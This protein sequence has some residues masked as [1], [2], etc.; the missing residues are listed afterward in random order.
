MK[1]FI[2]GLIIGLFI[3]A[4]VAYCYFRFG[5][6]PVATSSAP[7][8]FEKTM[9]RMALKARITKEAPKN[10]PIPP[11]AENLTTGA[12]VY[13]DNCAFCHGWP[14]QPASKAA[15]GM[16]PLPPQL[17][18]PD[19]MVTDDPVGVTYWKVKNGI[20]MT[21][22]PGFGEMLSDNEMWQVSEMLAHADKLPPATTAALQKP[23]VPSVEQQQPQPPQTKGRLT[24]KK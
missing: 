9:A 8:P 22:M 6:A 16:F 12:K 7:M 1:S 19:E 4:A 18:T 3:P 21:G 17:L 13:T 10:S 2:I 24:K 23:P 20:R 11:T 15:K 5:Y 14:N